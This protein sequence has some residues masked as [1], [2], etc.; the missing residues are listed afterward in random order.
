MVMGAYGHSRA[1]E[2]LFGGVTRAML[3]ACNLP[4]VLGH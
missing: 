4:L 3:T 1:R 2:A